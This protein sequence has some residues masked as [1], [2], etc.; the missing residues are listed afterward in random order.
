VGIGELSQRLGPNE[1]LVDGNDND[2][3][4]RTELERGFDSGER[5]DGA[6]PTVRHGTNAAWCLAPSDDDDI[7]P[8]GSGCVKHA[9]EHRNTLDLHKSLV[10]SH[11]P[12]PATCEHSDQRRLWIEGHGAT[13]AEV[14]RRPVRRP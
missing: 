4:T 10:S 3:A 8:E 2:L 5:T 7:R 6:G 1:W 11:P 14:D 13:V 9:F 12:A